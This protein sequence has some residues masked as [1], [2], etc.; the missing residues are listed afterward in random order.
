[1]DTQDGKDHL[2]DDFYDDFPEAAMS[3]RRE[4][5]I[6]ATIA[7]GPPLSRPSAFWHSRLMPMRDWKYWI[8]A[9][10]AFG[11]LTWFVPFG[12]MLGIALLA[13]CVLLLDRRHR[14]ID[15]TE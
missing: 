5:T 2:D 4:P 15:N 11:L 14:T 9:P 7:S 13:L 6:G 8:G 10:I 3:P 12:I 1:M